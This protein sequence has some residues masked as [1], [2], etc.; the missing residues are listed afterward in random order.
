MK[1]KITISWIIG[2]DNWAYKY[3]YENLSKKL[4]EYRHIVNKP[5]GDITII[6]SPSYFYPDYNYKGI[7]ILHVDSKRGYG[8]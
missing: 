5:D 1:D 7:T 2:H 4:P 3:I 6:M 8:L